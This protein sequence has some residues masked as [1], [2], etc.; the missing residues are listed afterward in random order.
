MRETQ[1]R[2]FLDH[3]THLDT[4]DRRLNQ[5]PVV[6]YLGFDATAESLHVGSLVMIM[7]LRW[8]QKDTLPPNRL[9]HAR[10]TSRDCCDHRK[11]MNVRDLK[12]EGY[13]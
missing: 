4:L 13:L 3:V 12:N 1:A 5:G 9:N 7:W 8:L 10:Q 11:S 6:A 2:G